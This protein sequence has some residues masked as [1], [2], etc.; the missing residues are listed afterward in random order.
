MSLNNFSSIH[1]VPLNEN[2]ASN[3]MVKSSLF[4]E[5][6]T[7]VPEIFPSHTQKCFFKPQSAQHDSVHCNH[8]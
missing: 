4:E 2:L 1:N 8:Q 3:N 7:S 5:V 6:Y